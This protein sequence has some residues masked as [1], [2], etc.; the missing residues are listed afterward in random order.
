LIGEVLHEIFT[1]VEQSVITYALPSFAGQLSKG[2][3]S[4]INALSR[5]A[6]K[7]GL[8]HTFLDIDDLTFTADKRFLVTY[9]VKPTAYITFLHR[10]VTSALLPLLEPVAIT[11]LP[12][13][14]FNPLKN[15]S[16]VVFY[17]IFYN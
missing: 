4:R 5:K 8:C 11:T 14:D 12:H 16:F 15:P 17:S 6:L 7:R 13:T 3:K 9:P 1:S 2:D 10:N